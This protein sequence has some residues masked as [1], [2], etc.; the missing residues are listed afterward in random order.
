[1]SKLQLLLKKASVSEWYKWVLNRVL[2]RAIPFN[3]PHH[4]RVLTVKS[5]H[6]QISLPYRRSNMNHVKGIHA[7]ALA[8]LCEYTVGLTLISKIK[9][10]G[11]KRKTNIRK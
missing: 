1:M 6:I 4:F 10:S 9:L 2:S 3:A 8:T 5:G 11:S 7:C